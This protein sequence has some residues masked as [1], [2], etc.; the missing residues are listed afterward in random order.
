MYSTKITRLSGIDSGM[1]ALL[2]PNHP[3]SITS[4]QA[5]AMKN[6]E[7]LR[8]DLSRRQFLGRSAQNAAGVAAGMV[9]LSSTVAKADKSSPVRVGIIGVRN[10]GRNL[11]SAFA[12]MSDVNVVSLCDVDPGLQSAAIKSVL[13]AQETSPRWESDFRNVLDDP[14]VDAVAIAT[15]DHWHAIMGIMAAQAGKDIYLEKP[16]SHTIEE[17]QLLIRAARKHERVMQTG[18][19]QRSGSHFQSA[20]EL[21]QSGKIGEVRLA[22]AWVAQSRKAFGR[23]A[24]EDPPEGVNY[25]LWLGPSAER[26]FN[27]HRFHHHWQWFNDYGTGELGNWGVHLLDVARWGLKLD[28]PERVSASGG[29]YMFKSGQEMPDTLAATFHYP[30]HTILWEH[31]LWSNHGLEGRGSGVSFHGE[32]GTLV[33]DRSGWKV[34]DSKERLNSDTSDQLNSHLRNF[35]DCVRTRQ[36]PNADIEIGHLS[37]TLCHLGNV[38]WQLNREVRFDEASQTFEDDV[39]A[40]KLLSKTYRDPWQL[41]KV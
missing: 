29:N 41:P 4:I 37:T 33:V 24:D 27:A 36:R 13:D 34:Y 15:P 22:K 10:Q 19:Q 21:V 11:A 32:N 39:E 23:C 40:N 7:A 14:Q 9:G 3:T 20:V 30:E 2:Y 1:L 6:A 5:P 38:A 12:K 18:L 16:V 26:P 17:G 31:R 25:D 28:L 8:R 35:I